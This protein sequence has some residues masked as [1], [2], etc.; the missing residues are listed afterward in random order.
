MEHL[1]NLEDPPDLKK[2]GWVERR[3]TVLRSYQKKYFVLDGQKFCWYQS[4]EKKKIAGY[5]DIDRAKAEEE[6]MDGKKSNNGFGFTVYLKDGKKNYRF[7]TDTH[8]AR[9]EW[10]DVINKSGD[11]TNELLSKWAKE[12]EC[13]NCVALS[14][15]ESAKEAAQESDK[16]SGDEQAM[17]KAD[18]P[19][20]FAKLQVKDTSGNIHLF[21]DIISRWDFTV[22]ALL[23]HFG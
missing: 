7:R 1:Q 21:R 19:E 17:D 15:L 6:D 10:M 22:I 16:E 9:A 14:A 13:V 3:T 20:K 5:I 23:R 2:E 12:D 8:K 11:Q 4:A 18:E